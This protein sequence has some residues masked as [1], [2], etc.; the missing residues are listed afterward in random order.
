MPDSTEEI[1]SDAEREQ[2]ERLEQEKLEKKKAK[3][4]KLWNFVQKITVP[5]KM[6]WTAKKFF[7]FHIIIAVLFGILTIWTFV[8]YWMTT[9]SQFRYDNQCN[10]E[11][12][13]DHLCHLAI[14][15]DQT[16]PAGSFIF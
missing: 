8:T 3:S 7:L 4:A 14:N 12:T 11:N 16:Y 10:Y 13:S 6:D 2:Q 15:V 1:N 5:Y 9:Y